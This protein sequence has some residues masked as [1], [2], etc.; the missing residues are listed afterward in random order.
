MLD[1]AFSIM[2]KRP[3]IERLGETRPRSLMRPIPAV[4]AEQNNHD[5]V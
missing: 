2:E 1:G 5:V 3:A 4:A